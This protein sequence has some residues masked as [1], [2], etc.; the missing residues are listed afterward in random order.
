MAYLFYFGFDEPIEQRSRE[1]QID[2]QKRCVTILPNRSRQQFFVH[3]EM[4][5]EGNQHRRPST[6][7]QK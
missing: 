6:K 7:G 4:A 3:V 1:I 5:N 2:E